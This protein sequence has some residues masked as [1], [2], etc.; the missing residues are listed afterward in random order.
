[1]A[2]VIRADDLGVGDTFQYRGTTVTVLREREMSTD[3]FG[4]L[5]FRFWCSRE[6][7]GA[8]G[9]MTF[10]PEGTVVQTSNS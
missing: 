10:G 6:D 1:M 3:M 2:D 5:M 4:R 9:W 8:E 7:T